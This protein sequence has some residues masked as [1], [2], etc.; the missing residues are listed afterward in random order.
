LSAK[1]ATTSLAKIVVMIQIVWNLR[2]SVLAV[3]LHNFTAK[4]VK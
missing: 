3:S 1:S 2:S 4:L